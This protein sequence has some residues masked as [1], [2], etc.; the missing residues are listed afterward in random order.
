MEKKRNPGVIL[1]NVAITLLCVAIGITAAM[2]YR[3]IVAKEGTEQSNVNQIADLRETIL[4][5]NA[6][7]ETVEMEK[8]E[9]QDRLNRIEQSSHDELLKSL[10]AELD[11]VKLFAGLTEVKGRGVYVQ[12]N[13]GDRTNISSL[14]NRLLLLVNELRASGAQAISINGKR[15]VAMS[16]IRVVNGNYISV[17]AEQLVAPYEIYAIGDPSKMLSGIPMGGNGLV[18]QINALTDTSCIW[19]TEENILISACDESVINTDHLQTK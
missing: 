12:I 9:L 18:H 3:S 1:R 16:E 8:E 4:N 2:Q 13:V 5:L 7:L 14:Q 6:T 19:R 11:S 17:H 15:I 10:Q